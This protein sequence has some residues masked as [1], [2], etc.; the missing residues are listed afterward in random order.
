M[1]LLVYLDDLILTARLHN[2]F[3]RKDI[4]DLNSFL[5]L[6]VAC[7]NDCLFLSQSKY[8][9]DILDRA[10]LL[11]AKPIHTALAPH[12]TSSII[13]YS[14]ADCGRCVA[15]RRST[16]EI[17]KCVLCSYPFLLY[18]MCKLLFYKYIV[19]PPIL[20]SRFSRSHL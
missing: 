16:Y 20:V 3:A 14:D 9:R 6:E 10:D 11:D 2:E 7:T 4:G 18:T 15:A 12:N 1:Y 19:S 5:G 17:F 8:V 13:G